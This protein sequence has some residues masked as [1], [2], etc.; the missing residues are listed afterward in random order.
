[1]CP[2][3]W[4]SKVIKEPGKSLRTWKWRP[5]ECG[6]D[7]KF[8][9]FRHFWTFSKIFC[10]VTVTPGELKIVQDVQRPQV[11]K[12]YQ[13]GGQQSL[14]VAM[15]TSRMRSCWILRHETRSAIK[16]ASTCPDL[17]EISHVWSE[18]DPDDIYR[19]IH[20]TRDVA[21]SRHLEY[22]ATKHGFV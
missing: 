19:S 9:R 8:L 14:G 13:N 7:E 5:A 16:L 12:S 22:L 10:W 17:P 20:T 18:T 11:I 6:H 4:W 3:H 1:M 15:A 2:R 21:A